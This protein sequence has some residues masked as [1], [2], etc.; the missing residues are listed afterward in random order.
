MKLYQVNIKFWDVYD[1]VVQIEAVSFT[2][3]FHTLPNGNRRSNNTDYTVTFSTR[4][5]ALEY[6]TKMMEKKL[7]NALVEVQQI[8]ARLD[9]IA[10]LKKRSK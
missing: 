3:N 10:G 9:L 1:P 6:A 4:E 2:A 7:N 8:K 5:A